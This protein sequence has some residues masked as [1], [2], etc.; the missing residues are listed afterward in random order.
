[1]PATPFD[2]RKARDALE[3]AKRA[4]KDAEQRFDRECTPENTSAL[5]REI[6]VQ[7]RRVADAKSALRRIETKDF[8]K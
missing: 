8:E 5:I 6:Q 1:M 4:L 7:E 3:K 2:M